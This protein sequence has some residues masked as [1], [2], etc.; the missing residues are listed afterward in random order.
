MLELYRSM[1][2]LFILDSLIGFVVL[3][4]FVMLTSNIQ[5]RHYECTLHITTCSEAGWS[6]HFDSPIAAYWTLRNC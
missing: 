6:L 2:K 4:F 5:C 1:S 3:D